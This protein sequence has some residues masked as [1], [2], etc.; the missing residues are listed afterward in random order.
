MVNMPQLQVLQVECYVFFTVTN[1]EENIPEKIL[2]W[3]YTVNYIVVSLSFIIFGY[4]QFVRYKSGRFPAQPR[5][6]R[7]SIVAVLSFICMA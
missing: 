6:K 3:L 2:L 4:F 7:T 1:R 5:S